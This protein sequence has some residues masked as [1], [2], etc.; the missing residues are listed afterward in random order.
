MP[1]SRDLIGPMFAARGLRA[2]TPLTLAG[3]ALV[4]ASTGQVI[5]ALRVYRIGESVARAET[6][7]GS[8]DLRRRAIAIAGEL[9]FAELGLGVLGRPSSRMTARDGFV[10]EVTRVATGGAKNAPSQIYGALWRIA[11]AMGYARLITYTLP[12][13]SGVSPRAAGFSLES[14]SSGGGGWSRS[15]R[16]R[17]DTHPL[18]P[19]HKWAKQTSR[20]AAASR[21]ALQWSSPGRPWVSG[22]DIREIA[23]RVGSSEATQLTLFRQR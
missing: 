4:H 8:S 14:E 11:R 20:Y 21:A 9:G 18:E 3:V 12:S 7:C 6:V 23:R 15:G 17:G 22:D 2:R 13:E 1:T 16:E 5:D 10:A 19:K